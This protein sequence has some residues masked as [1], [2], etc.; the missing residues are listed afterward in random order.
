MKCDNCGKE[1]TDYYKVF[2]YEW[3]SNVIRVENI[4]GDYIKKQENWCPNCYKDSK[5]KLGKY[6][7]GG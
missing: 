4:H 2:F 5:F 1:T 7:I 3:D 6:I